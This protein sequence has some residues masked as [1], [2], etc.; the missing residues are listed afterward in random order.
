MILATPIDVRRGLTHAQRNALQI[1]TA[2]R[3]APRTW[4]AVIDGLSSA[5]IDALLLA[6]ARA[7][8]PASDLITMAEE[9]R[10]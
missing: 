5:E 10:Q 8:V 7:G 1:Y 2:W 6:L 3:S 4:Q 9:A